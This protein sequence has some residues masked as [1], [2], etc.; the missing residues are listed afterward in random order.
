MSKNI[1]FVVEGERTEPR[2][3]KRLVTVMRTYK[4]YKVFSYSAN[5][6]RMLEGMFINREIDED[7]DFLEYLRSC[8][9]QTDPDKVLDMEF[10]DIFLFFD[11]DPQDQKYDPEK[12]RKAV[13]YFNDS[14]ENGKLYIN[15]PMME[16]FRHISNPE[17]L[18]FLDVMVQRDQIPRYKERV[19][20]EGT[21]ELSDISKVS[22]S[23]MLRV[24][25]LNLLKATLMI[26]GKPEMPTADLFREEITQSNIL[27]EELRSLSGNDE[28]FVLN[29]CVFNTIDY[30]SQRFFEKMNNKG[31][32]DI[33]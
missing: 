1:L 17:D 4:D 33:S 31:S 8:R 24:I 26:T 3:L 21:P 6:Y 22:E 19:A 32:D 20:R 5:I 12:L 18:S 16:S 10:S 7:L 23:M 25:T 13:L 2:F 9:G 27:S 15:Y 30:N 29:T 14:T 28:L 11:M